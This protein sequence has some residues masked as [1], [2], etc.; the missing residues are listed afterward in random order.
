MLQRC[1]HEVQVVL[2]QLSTDPGVD[3]SLYACA[4]CHQHIR[5]VHGKTCTCAVCAKKAVAS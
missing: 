1:S 5:Y 2:Q 3:V 4:D